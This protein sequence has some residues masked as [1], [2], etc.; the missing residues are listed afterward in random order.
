MEELDAWRSRWSWKSIEIKK[1]IFKQLE[2]IVSE[3]AILATNTSSL[4]VTEISTANSHPAG[5]IGV[6]FFNPAPVQGFDL[7]QLS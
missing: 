4:S 7:V 3:D 6:H 1:Q 2:G 5:V